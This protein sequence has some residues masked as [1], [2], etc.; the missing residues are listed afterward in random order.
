MLCS[1]CGVEEESINHIIFEC[2]DGLQ[3]WIMSK[4]PSHHRIFP[5]DLVFSNMIIYFGDSQK[6]MFLAIFPVV[7]MKK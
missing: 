3:I 1:I 7:Y 4:I 5:S 2:P 6:I